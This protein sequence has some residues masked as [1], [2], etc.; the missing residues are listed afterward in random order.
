MVGGP[1]LEGPGK[2]VWI[3]IPITTGICIVFLM[4]LSVWMF[5]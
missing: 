3:G 2:L 4:G 1:I 5:W